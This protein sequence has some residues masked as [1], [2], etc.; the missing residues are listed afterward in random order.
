MNTFQKNF[1]FFCHFYFGFK[2]KVDKALAIDKTLQSS[3]ARLILEAYF[4]E[5]WE[6]QAI[7][8]VFIRLFFI[9]V[10]TN[11]RVGWDK[12]LDDI[13]VK[14]TVLFKDEQVVC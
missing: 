5:L 3:K 7:F 1:D 14:L 6:I 2:S 4:R 11:P 8:V 12:S 13:E 10:S 9:W